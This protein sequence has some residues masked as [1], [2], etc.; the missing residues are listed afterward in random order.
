MSLQYIID[1]NNVLHNPDFTR[2]K[3]SRDARL[4]LA[5]FI[6]MHKLTGSVKNK[7]S[8]VF[9]GYPG[10]AQ[11]GDGLSQNIE[12]I[13]SRKETADQTIK[14]ILEKAANTKNI[15]TVSDD[16]E[17]IIFTRLIGARSLGVKD[18]IRR[19]D[20]LNRTQTIPLKPELTYTQMHKIN[21][22]LRKIWLE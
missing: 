1:G 9:D 7:V 17:I 2:P 6:M 21:Q 10:T 12:I 13:F 4:A 3:H 14:R 19:K 15:L 5:D 8:I 20:R 22:E 11:P 16:K 18:F